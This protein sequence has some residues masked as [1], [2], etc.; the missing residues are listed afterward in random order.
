MK[1]GIYEFCPECGRKTPAKK[2]PPNAKEL[3]E[4]FNSEIDFILINMV[5]LICKNKK[6]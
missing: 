5:C 4:K 1:K 6:D 2:I 3:F